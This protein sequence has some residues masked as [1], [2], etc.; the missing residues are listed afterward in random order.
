[1]CLLDLSRDYK[2]LAASIQGLAPLETSVE[3]GLDLFAQA[4]DKYAT[5]LATLATYD[6]EWLGEIH[7]YMSYHN[8]MK[9]RKSQEMEVMTCSFL[10]L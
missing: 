2:E 5:H 6:T 3:S 1:M 7:D 9:V 10:F 4:T 8:A